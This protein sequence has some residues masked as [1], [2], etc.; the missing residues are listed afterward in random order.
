MS[1]SFTSSILASAGQS[2]GFSSFLTTSAA[3][4]PTYLVVS[5]LD[6]NEYT[7]ASNGSTGSLVGN[8]NTATFAADGGDASSLGALFTYNASTGQYVSA[9]YGTLSSLVLKASTDTGRN[10]AISFY[11]SNDASILSPYTTDAIGLVQNAGASYLGTVS[12]ITQPALVGQ[13]PSQATPNSIAAVAQT[14]VGQTWNVNGCWNLACSIAAEA[15]ASLP[16][17]STLVGVDGQA[18]GEWMVAY[19]GP[20]STS[21][22][23][24]S[25]LKAGDVVVFKTAGGTGHVTTVTSGSGTGAL[26]IDNTEY[27]T[28]SGAIYN[29]A[30]DG[31]ASDIVIGS[32]HAASAEFSGVDAAS[33]VVYRLDTPIV[34]AAASAIYE[35]AGGSKAL[36]SLVSAADPAGKAIVSYQVYDTT[37]TDSVSVGESA[38]TASSA[39]SAVT[40]SASQLAAVSITTGTGFSGL[41]T[42]TIM[43][44]ASNGSYWG[45]WTAIS[46][47]ATPGT[48]TTTAAGFTSSLTSFAAAAQ[49]GA[50]GSIRLTDGGTPTVTLS[51]SQLTLDHAAVDKITG[52]YLLSVTG[53]NQATTMVGSNGTNYF[54]A[55]MSGGVHTMR[56]GASIGTADTLVGGLG[57]DVLYGSINAAGAALLVAGAG[58]N[59]L[60]GGLGTDKLIGGGKSTLTA[61]AAYQV[62]LGG[63]AVG[64]SDTLN[65]AAG[66]HDFLAVAMGNNTLNA[67]RG[68]GSVLEGGAGVDHLNGST[69]ASG[70]AILIGGTGATV[71]NGGLGADTL[72]GGGASLLNA[73]SGAPELLLGG[74]S[75][76]AH[77]TLSAG[78]NNAT[79][80]VA[81][82]NNVLYA[83]TGNAT[84][85]GGAG[86][87]LIVGGGGNG[88]LIA[89]TGHTTILGGAGS[90]TLVGTGQ[91]LLIGGSGANGTS[92]LIGGYSAGAHDTLVGGTGGN[93]TLAVALGNNELH[94]DPS[95]IGGNDLLI[96]GGRP[97]HALRRRRDHQLHRQRR[98]DDHRWRRGQRPR[99]RRRPRQP[100][101][102]RRHGRDQRRRFRRPQRGRRDL[103][104]RQR[105]HHDQLRQQQPD[106]D[107]EPCE[108]GGVRLRPHH[109]RARRLTPAVRP[110]RRAPAPRRCARGRPDRPCPSRATE[111]RPGP[112][113]R[114]GSSGRRR[115]GPWRNSGRPTGSRPCAW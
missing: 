101:V 84:V 53:N 25:S 103:Q 36:G 104:H 73:G 22:T 85:L 13:A 51:A 30:K 57:A 20:S 60:N 44:R 99:H 31:S 34:T 90:D 21:S 7:V 39:T 38:T 11:G 28:S 95:G 61:G 108:R 70:A 114:R 59:V 63:Y 16:A 75:A 5:G 62:L 17:I 77:D 8:G 64:S 89:G 2:I 49:A 6:R 23:W 58:A 81:T 69:A 79:L 71:L 50:L 18:N 35:T 4:D 33:V 109:P 86:N 111:D 43:V 9:T 40:V 14:F 110:P 88:V 74:Y 32:A 19:N 105:R 27:V 92:L 66:G 102:R 94:A 83:G 93:E 65:G 107:P 76:G 26:V 72:V 1:L 68:V 15:G 52:S 115:P 46:V 112:P 10:E 54:N 12:V 78:S 29:A 91:S 96:A 45:D 97:R 67:G 47:T 41:S 37:A 113:P 100:D 98:P 80:A 55:G 82:G 3:N 56:A 24:Q 87:D 48:V 42:G 106:G